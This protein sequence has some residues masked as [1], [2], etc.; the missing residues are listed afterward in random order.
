VCLY[1]C[2]FQSAGD[3]S[4]PS[5]CSPGDSGDDNNI[6]PFLSLHLD[7]TTSMSDGDEDLSMR[8]PYIPMGV[9]DDFPLLMS[10]DLM[11]GAL[12]DKSLSCKT[13]GSSKSS[14][15]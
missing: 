3:C 8:A 2:F 1:F 12:P 11:W 9:G 5:L 10:T 4:L 14:S 13:N 7:N 15:W 6:S